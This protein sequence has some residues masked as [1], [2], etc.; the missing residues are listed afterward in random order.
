MRRFG[1]YRVYL[2]ME[3]TSA[4]A[5]SMIY[6]I[7]AVYYVQTVGLNPLQLVLVGTVLELAAFIFEVP[8]GVV[9]DT[10][11]RRLSVI[12]GHFLIG[13]CFVVEGF[14][15][16]FGVILAA[17]VVRGVG[18]TFISGALEAWIAD[19]VG[20]EQIGRVYARAQQVGNLGALAGIVVGAGLAMLQLNL[21]IAL[22]G[23]ILIGLGIVLIVVMPEH[24]FKPAPRGEHSERHSWRAM[25]STFRDGLKLVRGSSLLLILMAVSMVFGSFSEGLDR[26]WEAHFL[27][28]IGLPALGN[29]QPVAWF[30]VINVG[31]MLLSLLVAEFV[32]RRVDMTS[33]AN[34]GRILFVGNAVL[35]LSVMAFGLAGNFLFALAACWLAS[36][37]RTFIGPIYGAWLNQHIPSNVRATVLSMNG[38]ANAFGQVVGGPVVGAIGTVFSIRA[39][40]VVSGL[41]LSPALVL[42]ARTFDRRDLPQPD[43]TPTLAQEPGQAI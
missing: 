31:G 10:Y 28:D 29:L 26:L 41:L 43:T 9:A 38:Q 5:Q 40:L 21:P 2:A 13:A 17:E 42:Y 6:T 33:H 3:A 14:V 32:R 1:A 11:S 30:G 34:T 12:I 18:H 25:G 27:T 39:A 37:A 8:T 24:G 19:E 7:V 15:P 23:A 4:F 16:L 20:T 36:M 22:G 35:A